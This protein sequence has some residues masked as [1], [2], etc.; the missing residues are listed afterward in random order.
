MAAPAEKPKEVEWPN[1]HELERILRDKIL[2][3]WFPRCIDREGGGF[4][5]AF[6]ED[7]TRQKVE[8]KFIVYQ[9]RQTWVTAAVALADPALRTRYLPHLNHGMKFLVDTMWDKQYGGFIEWVDAEGKPDGRW[10]PWKQMYG[11][12]FGIYAA[13]GAYR[14]TKNPVALGL[15]QR[16]FHW[17]D[18]MAHDEAN[19]GYYEL[20]TAEGYPVA[21]EGYG[22]EALRRFPIIGRVGQKSMNAHIHIL[23]ALTALRQVWKDG[24]LTERLAEV[25]EIVRDKI[26]QPG[27]HLAMFSRPDFDPLEERSSFGHELET[28]YLLMEASEVLG[29]R[30]DH[31]TARVAQRL[32]DHSLRWG[33]DQKYGGFYDEGPPRGW[34][35]RRQKVWWVQAEALNG[36]LAAIGIAGREDARFA[37]ALARTWQFFHDHQLD[38]RYGGCYESVQENGEPINSRRY[39][40]SRWKTAYHVVRALLNTI[41]A[42]KGMPARKG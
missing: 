16:A 38:R 39:K 7:W 18:R 5:E 20:L 30:G 17:I 31:T 27:G 32:V 8:T 42:L 19:G 21:K 41:A 15:A 35:E 10:M 9:A 3:A 34:P 1:F 22:E 28:A 29:R 11:Q 24:Q 33:F 2:G 12:A 26:V 4:Y 36:L 25:F 13:A 40:A 6:T 37:Y 14:A 23:E